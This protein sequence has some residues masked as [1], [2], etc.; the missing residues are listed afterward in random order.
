MAQVLVRDLDDRTVEV[1]KSRAARH[2]RSLNQEIRI[3]LEAAATGSDIDWVAVAGTIRE[4]LSKRNIAFV[5][6]GELQAEDR[7]R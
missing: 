3:I 6:S 5:D 1:L 2:R 4:N 7:S